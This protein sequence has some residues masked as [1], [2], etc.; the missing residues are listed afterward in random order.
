MHQDTNGKGK[1]LLMSIARNILFAAVFATAAFAM[2]NASAAAGKAD[3]KSIAR[4]R[5]IAQI[6][7]C[8]DCH[9]A[10][11]AP[12]GGKVQ[13]KDWLQG[14]ALGWKGDWGTTYAVNLRTYMQGMTEEQWVKT[15]RN[16]KARPPMPWFALNDMHDEDLRAFYRFVRYL[17]PAGG[18]APSYVPP[19]QTPN[20]PYA[21]FPAAPK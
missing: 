10:G 5:Y 3:D 21:Q 2:A 17:G 1:G 8:N 16:L 13:E 11:Y 15:A 7:G 4:G 14:D 18:P 12:R 9:T 20:G 6:A 19:G